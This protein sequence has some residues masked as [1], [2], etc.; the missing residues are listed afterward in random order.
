MRKKRKVGHMENDETGVIQIKVEAE[1]RDSGDK[2]SDMPKGVFP[3]DIKTEIKEEITTGSGGQHEASSSSSSSNTNQ[4]AELTTGGHKR[5]AEDR[6][7]VEAEVDVPAPALSTTLI[8][9]DDA[10][11]PDY[12]LSEKDLKALQVFKSRGR[13]QYR[14][15]D[16]KLTA[17]Q[18]HGSEEEIG[19]A[20]QKRLRRKNFSSKLPS[21]RNLPRKLAL[22][23]ALGEY[24]LQLRSDSKL[25][26][27][28]IAGFCTFTV[29]QVVERMCQM[30]YLYDYCNMT[31]YL[32][33]A[34]NEFRAELNTGYI[35]DVPVFDSAEYLALNARSSGYPLVWPWMII[36]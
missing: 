23:N 32:R 17:I 9:R 11:G 20:A 7:Q 25:C 16:L 18:K 2:I 31:K 4:S 35:P 12:C 36:E 14:L 1:D 19:E 3:A 34:E 30:K 6:G 28:Y 27:S 29:D 22:V 24:K 33:R 8:S 15:R 21:W 26:A 5:K 10:L 13:N